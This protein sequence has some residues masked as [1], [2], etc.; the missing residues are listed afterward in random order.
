MAR[1]YTE[2]KAYWYKQREAAVRGRKLCVGGKGRGGCIKTWVG[3]DVGGAWEVIRR[4]GEEMVR[5]S[6]SC[7][8]C[9]RR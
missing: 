1:G 9:D 2:K 4:Q 8:R 6:Q 7:W 3:R 5:L